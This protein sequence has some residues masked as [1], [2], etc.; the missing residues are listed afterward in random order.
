M[1]HDPHQEEQNQ[2]RIPDCFERP[3][4][5]H[6]HIPTTSPLNDSGDSVEAARSHSACRSSTEGVLDVFYD[7]VV[8]ILPPPHHP[9]VIR[10]RISFAKVMMTP[11]ASV[12]KAV[13]SLRRVMAF[14]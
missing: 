1:L 4:D 14:E 8:D 9:P 7:P 11:P 3:V 13:C 2:K 10:D 5:I 6:H 12:E